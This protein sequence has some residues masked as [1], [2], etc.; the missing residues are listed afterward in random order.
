MTQKFE[1]AGAY[2]KDIIDSGLKSLTALSEGAQAIATEAA[3]YI[4]AS[5]ETGNAA[6]EK[7]LSAKSLET[8]VEVQ[9]DYVRQ[10][11]EGFVAEATRFSGLYADIAKDAFQPFESIGAKVG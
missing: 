3:E 7:L 1:D 8:V 9:T 4:R 5:F 6:M 11:Y 2:G 10:A